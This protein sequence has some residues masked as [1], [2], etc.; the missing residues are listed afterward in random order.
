M[1]APPAVLEPILASVRERAA[2]RRRF[3]SLADLRSEV[4]AEPGRGQRFTAALRGDGLSVLAECKR[5]SPSAGAL[6][7]ETDLLPRARAYA[8][9][10]AAALSVLTEE[11]HFHGHPLDLAR[12]AEAGLPRLRKDFLLDEAMVLESWEMGA[13]AILL[14]ACVLPDP[15]LGELR[16]LA[17]EIGLSV[18]LEVHEEGEL[19]RGIAADPDCLGV[20]ARNLRTLEVDLAVVDRLL[21]QAPPTSVRVAESGVRDLADLKRVRKAGADAVLVGETLMRAEDPR[22]TLREWRRALSVEPT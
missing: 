16:A 17:R 15:L 7:G 12:V 11:D 18:L 13:D 5:R 4:R 8:E 6:S 21:P 19:E 3:R 10:G 2:E 14:L 22:N 9:G 20:N 1:K